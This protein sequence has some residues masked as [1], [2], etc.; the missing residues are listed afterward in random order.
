MSFLG[1]IFRKFAW[2]L[3]GFITVLKEENSF[4]FYV[5]VGI[6]LLILSIIGSVFWNMQGYEWAIVWGVYGTVVAFE[7]INTLVENLVDIIS[8]EYNISARK[9]KDI[10]AAATLFNALVATTVILIV[11]ISLIVGT[12]S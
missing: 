2:A 6:G 11:F 8:F 10:G 5:I 12:Y 1:K 3:S 4:I 7:F 9:I